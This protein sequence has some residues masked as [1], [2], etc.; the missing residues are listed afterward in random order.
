M[1]NRIPNFIKSTGAAALGLLSLSS[2][3]AQV[4]TNVDAYT[5]PTWHSPYVVEP[6]L[7]VGDTVPRA[8]NPAQQFQMIGIPDGLG[9]YQI[10][11]FNAMLFV[12]HEVTNTALTRPIIGESRVRGTFVSAYRMERLR[13]GVLNGD[14]AFTQIYNG[15]T[16]VGPLAREDNTTP[17]FSRFCS[18]AVAGVREGFDRNIYFTGEESD[19]PSTFDSRGGSAVAIFDNK[20]YLLPDMGH[21]PWENLLPM[22]RID[23]GL[24]TNKTVIM[25]ME[26]GPASTP[27][28]GLFLYVGTKDKNSADPL[29]KN[30][31][32][33][34]QFYVLRS[35]DEDYNSEPDFYGEGSAV[36]GEWV[37]IPN[38]APKTYS[39]LKDAAIAQDFFRFSRVED[40]AWS[41]TSKTDFY[42]VTTGGDGFVGDGTG[43]NH[44][45]RMY[46]VAMDPQNPLGFVTLE[47]I[48]DADHSRHADLP[49]SPDN[50]DT[51]ARYIM[52]N[53]DG[54]ST[55]RPVMA[56]RKRDGSIWRYDLWDV[57]APPL[58]V[59]ALTAMGR[60]G[61]YANPGSVTTPTTLPTTPTFTTS[62]YNI[63][64]RGIW[65]TSG[66]IDTNSIF[67][68]DTFVF[69]VQA[70]GPTAAP[71]PDTVEDGQILILLP[72][73]N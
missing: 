18:G 26:D 27:Y 38:I 70:H 6:I 49:L 20:A 21:L 59:A 50:I 42:F 33:G 62:K 40:G 69:N 57:T 63:T 60:D 51:S 39:Q 37:R 1:K 61:V 44:L 73:R 54:H 43:K 34:G 48:G 66:I 67:G 58:R 4:F 65:E 68:D 23:T 8:S 2:A 12:N 5:L 11:Q 47:V 10:N 72:N 35:L 29:V 46:H 19:A 17:A 16:L 31:L 7:S 52:V 64:Q 55:T 25:L 9:M 41:K 22:P 36:Q 24:Y 71:A 28:C 53:E 30:G 14:L 45:G 56:Q 3:C 15:S 13:R 32:V